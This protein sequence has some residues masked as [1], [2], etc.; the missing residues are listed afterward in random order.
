MTCVVTPHKSF[1]QEGQDHLGNPGSGA[2]RQMPYARTDYDDIANP[3]GN[4]V[5]CRYIHPRLDKHRHGGGMP[6]T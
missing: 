4:G 6:R 3:A 2:L 1:W 5:L